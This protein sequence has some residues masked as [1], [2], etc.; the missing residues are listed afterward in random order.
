[1]IKRDELK[2]TAVDRLKDARILAENNRFEGAAYIC[3]YA[4]EIALKYAIC[5]TL[6]WEEFPF[7]P[8]EFKKLTNFRTH[9][10][11]ILL[12]LSG[13]ESR[14]KSKLLYEWSVVLEWSP[15]N[16]YG[17]SNITVKKTEDML[18]CTEILLEEIWRI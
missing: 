5:G 8:G 17:N 7:T 14:I 15:E 1:M 13:I 11:E 3:G 10:L 2:R 12:L 6:N 9:D 18:N 16:R 4:V